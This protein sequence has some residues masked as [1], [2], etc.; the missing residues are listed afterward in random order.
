MI[1]LG[2]IGLRVGMRH[3]DA[4]KLCEKAE[5][6]A[7]CDTNP[8]TL[9]AGKERF[10]NADTYTDYRDM[11]KDPTLDG[12]VVAT[13]DD[14]HHEMVI[15]TL[16]AGKHVMCEKPFALHSDECKDMIRVSEET[17]KILMVGQ[18]CRVAPA[19]VKAKAIIDS[20]MLGDLYFIESE[21]AHDYVDIKGW[22]MDPKMKRHPVTGGGCHPIDLVRWLAGKE[23]TEAFAYGTHE[24]LKDWPCDDSTISL[25]KFDDSLSAKVY[26]S[27]GCKRYYSMRTVIYGTK[28]TI[29]AD[30][31][32]ATMTV[33]LDKLGEET[34]LCGTKMREVAHILPVDVASHNFAS[35]IKEFCDSI[36]ENRQPTI[37][38]EE[39]AKAVAICEAIIRSTESGKPEAIV[40]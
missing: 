19:F 15:A 32:S 6:A 23:A 24:T 33:Y 11:L 10:P 27:V 36:L 7:I 3:A 35:E 2:V 21:Y 16:R 18:V 20:G 22:R 38:A 4:V 34:S 12:I 5:L 17:G 30:N 8:D 39:G 9:A 13:P 26:V 29:I 28:G 37:P 31:Q 25:I 40:Y 1:R 14:L